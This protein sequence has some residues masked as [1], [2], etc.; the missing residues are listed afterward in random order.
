MEKNKYP[1]GLMMPNELAE[2]VTKAA[3]AMGVSKSGYVRYVL[4]KEFAK[5]ENR[6]SDVETG[7]PSQIS[8][9]LERE[10]S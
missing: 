4:I 3:K 8:I 1:M 2:K 10:N 7:E 5:N 6:F 9:R